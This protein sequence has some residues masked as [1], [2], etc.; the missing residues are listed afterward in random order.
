MEKR[1]QQLCHI[2]LFVIPRSS[3]RAPVNTASYFEVP[4]LHFAGQFRADPDTRNNINC[5]FDPKS[6]ISNDTGRDYNINGTGEFSLFD[7]KVT[8]AV[9]ETGVFVNDPIINRPDC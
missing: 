8:S 9:D 6:S 4:R 2:S 5:N 7:I 1:N 3:C